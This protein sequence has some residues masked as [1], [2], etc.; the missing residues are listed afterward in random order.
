MTRSGFLVTGMTC[1]HCEDSVRAEVGAVAGV[2]DLTVD[3]TTGRLE[4]TGEV[5]AAAIIAAVAE[6]GYSASPAP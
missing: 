5:D 1:G 4:V 6:A 3:H 2:I